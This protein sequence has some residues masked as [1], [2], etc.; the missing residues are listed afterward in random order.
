MGGRSSGVQEFR[1]SGVQEFRSSGVQE[2]RSSGVQDDSRQE[3]GPRKSSFASWSLEE[4]RDEGKHR[5][6]GTEAAE[7]RKE[8]RGE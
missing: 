4:R 2:F 3:N 6:E 7:W 5:T 1:S 8:N